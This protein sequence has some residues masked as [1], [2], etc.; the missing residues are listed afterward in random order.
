MDD[1]VLDIFME[2]MRRN[3]KYDKAIT[4]I[5]SEL[6]IKDSFTRISGISTF[7]EHLKI[8]HLPSTIMS[9]YTKEEKNELFPTDNST[10]GVVRTAAVSTD[11]L[12]EQ[13][14]EM[15][16]DM[17][18]L[19][20][21][22]VKAMSDSNQNHQSYTRQRIDETCEGCGMYGHNVYQTGCDRCAQYIMIK[23]YLEENPQNIRSILAKY[24]KH[25]K[26]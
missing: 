23:K 21:A 24:K 4:S 17:S 26:N 19:V 1:Q 20:Q 6:A 18:G 7:P 15:E 22:I 16:Y 25:Q 10:E 3:D 8:Y 9:F 14:L 12:E 2:E 5:E 13:T 11:A